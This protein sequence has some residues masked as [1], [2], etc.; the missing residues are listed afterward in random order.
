M[1]S[2]YLDSV[3]VP[4]DIIRDF[5][6]TSPPGALGEVHDVPVC[7]SILG[8]DAFLHNRGAAAIT[9]AFNGQS[10]ITVN[11]GDVYV[12]NGVKFWLV[13][14]IAGTIYDFQVF[15]IRTTTLRRMGL[16]KNAGIL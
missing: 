10:P 2:N 4:S 5:M 6:Y 11:A 1:S 7:F 9:I 15:G 14:V 3:I 16:L 8:L 12:L 13:E